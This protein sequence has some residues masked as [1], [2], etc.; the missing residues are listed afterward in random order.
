[1]G[2]GQKALPGQGEDVGE[3]GGGYAAGYAVSAAPPSGV[4]QEGLDI[5]AARATVAIAVLRMQGVLQQELHKQHLEIY[6]VL[7]RG[8]FGTVY[9]GA[10]LPLSMCD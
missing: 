3:V 8:G 9:H 10:V 1:M 4:D 2:S 6:S 5:Y 7:G